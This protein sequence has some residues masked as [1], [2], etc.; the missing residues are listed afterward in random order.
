MDME[1]LMALEKGIQERKREEGR[2]EIQA[3]LQAEADALEAVGSDG[4]PLKRV[5]RIGMVVD[6][7]MGKARLEVVT[8]Y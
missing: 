2:A 6:T 5:R 4:K 7:S 1:G 3:R 8:G